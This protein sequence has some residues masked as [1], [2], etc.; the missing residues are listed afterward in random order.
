MKL[1]DEIPAHELEAIPH[2]LRAGLAMYFDQRVETGAF[3]R[4]VLENDLVGAAKRADRISFYSL[5]PLVNVLIGYAPAHA[6]GSKEAVAR[7][8]EAGKEPR[9]P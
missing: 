6:W 1:F 4:S 3:L 8:L 7:W 2:H 5:H 9:R